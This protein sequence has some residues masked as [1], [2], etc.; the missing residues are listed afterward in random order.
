[1]LSA[2]GG[3]GFHWWWQAAVDFVG[4]GCQMILLAAGGG[5]FHRRQAVTDDGKQWLFLT[6]RGGLGWQMAALRGDFSSA[7]GSSGFH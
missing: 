6:G 5:V 3:G 4:R 1:L 7:A 2:A